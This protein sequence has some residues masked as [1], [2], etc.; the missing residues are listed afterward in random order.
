V[1]LDPYLLS[2]EEADLFRCPSDF[3]GI[4]EFNPA[5]P[6]FE[7]YG[8]SYQ[9]NNYLIGPPVLSTGTAATQAL[10]I[11]LNKRMT[12]FKETDV[13]CPTKVILMGDYPW[14]NQSRRET[15]LNADWHKQN[16][17]FNISFL[18][19]HVN[20]RKIIT[21]SLITDD[22]TSIPFDSLYELAGK[23]EEAMRESMGK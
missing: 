7:D 13:H 22:Y 19:G 23:A 21:P 20:F 6:V 2:P 1:E 9:M 15:K 10:H 16:G 4:N 8:T 17:N 5:L 11:A 3:G 14:W 18:D 12:G